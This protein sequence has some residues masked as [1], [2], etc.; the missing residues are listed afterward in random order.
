MQSGLEHKSWRSR[1][2]L[3]R[4]V[5]SHWS[6]CTQD[7]V[8]LRTQILAGAL[9]RDLPTTLPL[10]ILNTQLS[11]QWP[12]GLFYYTH[13][14]LLLIL[15]VVLLEKQFEMLHWL[16]AVCFFLHKDTLLSLSDCKM[17]WWGCHSWRSDSLLGNFRNERAEHPSLQKQRR[18]KTN[19]CK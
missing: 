8:H 18:G 2:V 1:T 19:T 15:L 11:F 4:A 10:L 3:E 14:F 16:S 13:W 6:A 12:C 5:F 9:K 7:P 17:F